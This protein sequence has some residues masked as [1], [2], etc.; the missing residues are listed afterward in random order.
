MKSTTG[1]IGVLNKYKPI[2][3]YGAG[4]SGLVMAYF[5]EKRGFKVEI[6]EREDRA[7][8]KIGTEYLSHGRA[9]T[10]A[11]AIFTNDDVWELLN[12]LNLTPL[13]ANSHLKKKIFR[14]SIKK[15]SPLNFFEILTV[16]LKLF[17]KTPKITNE[18]T[19]EEFFL[20]L[21]GKRLCQETSRVGVCSL[22]AVPVIRDRLALQG[23]LPCL[24]VWRSKHG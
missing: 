16:L 22:L 20:P 14:G 8:G 13:R 10:A 24:K 11:N 1:P 21:F 3:I 17:K 6:H 23:A 4:I 18:L 9:E 2:R 5:L 19:V 15:L 12:D 7:G